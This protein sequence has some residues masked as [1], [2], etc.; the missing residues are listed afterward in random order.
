[1]S[2]PDQL[3]ILGNGFDLQCELASTF[4]DFE[5]PRKYMINTFI[6]KYTHCEDMAG[7]PLS[8]YDDEERPGK[9]LAADLQAGGITAWDFILIA[10][11]QVRTWYD[12]EACIRDWLMGYA[13]GHQSSS[14]NQ[15]QTMENQ[16]SQYRRVTTREVSPGDYEG[17][18]ALGNFINDSVF[19]QLSV[20]RQVA[21]LL[22]KWYNCD[23]DDNSVMK[24]M[25][26]ELHRLEA[27]FSS[28]MKNV[29]ESNENYRSRA[30]LLLEQLMNDQ[31]NDYNSLLT[32][33]TYKIGGDII[34][35]I[36]NHN[37]DTDDSNYQGLVKFTKTYR[38]MALGKGSKTKLVHPRVS[39]Q[40]GS[41]T[42]IIKFFGHSLGD[43][44]YSYF[45]AIFDEVNLYGSD[46]RLVFYY[47]QN[48]SN[49]NTAEE[50]AQEEMFEK[51]NRLITTYGQTL[52]NKD[53]GRNLM[54]KLLLENR[55]QV[56][57]GP[58]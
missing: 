24:A 57:Q 30:C 4:T 27:A 15:L 6:K 35:G 2:V 46:T 13:E 36:D 50:N 9:S 52:D 43:P 16:Y 5:E 49:K 1:M 14:E 51:V 21:K 47:N 53:H 45:Q 33:N 37:V 48:R 31:L 11:E 41:E 38:L 20:D 42:S 34:F 39:G 22:L 17:I 8:L 23:A 19:E 3:L 10:D 44:D 40:P 26:Q 29:A 56:V 32:D 58:V 28:Y 12:V 7:M 25:M 18:A 55:L 54:H